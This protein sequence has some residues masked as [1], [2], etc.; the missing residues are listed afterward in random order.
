[1]PQVLFRDC[2]LLDTLAGDYKPGQHVL[3][4]GDRIR[5][6]SDRPLQAPDAQVVSPMEIIQR[7]TVV[8]AEILN[9]SGELGVIAAEAR[10]D[11]LV[12]D[13][14]PVRDL[15]LLAD[16]GAHLPVIMKGGSFVVNRL[17]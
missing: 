3:V 2:M 17:S 15:K 11:L 5:E 6:V 9:R 13:G 14:D 16:Q 4:E 10:A 8:N 7:A 1:M 12:V